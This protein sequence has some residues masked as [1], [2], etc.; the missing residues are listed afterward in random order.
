MGELLDQTAQVVKRTLELGADEVSASMA[1][2]THVTIQRRGGVV[3]QATEAST[4]GLAVS[5]LANDRFT[6]SSTSD[7]RPVA[8]E[9]FLKRCVD[10]ANYLEPDAD[11]ALPAEGLCGRGVTDEALDQYDPAWSQ[12][13]AEQRAE[14]A[15][16][17]E[18]AIHALHNDQVIS[19]AAYVADGAAETVTVMSN[20]FADETRGAWFAA[21]GEMTLQDGAK[22]P[23]AHAYY[24]AR[25]LTDLPDIPFI[26]AELDRRAEQRKGGGPIASGTYPMILENR[27]AARILGVLAGGLSGGALHHGRSFLAGKLGTRIGTDLLHIVDDPLLPRGLGSRPWDGDA[28]RSRK[29]IIVEHGVLREY[30]IDVYHGRKLDMTPTSG[31][32]S[33][34]I[35]PTSAQ[36]WR[37]IAKPWS[38]AILVNGF[39]GGNSNGTTGD[40]SFGILGQ[41][42]ENGEPTSALAEMNVS[43]NANEIFH[44]LAAVGNDPWTYGA[45][46][47]PTLVFEDVTFSGS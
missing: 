44:R 47:T 2:S 27:A 24:G 39:L 29:R 1:A 35:L 46:V 6:S 33:N 9:A 32:R 4:R 16:Q 18:S 26:A 12:Q 10:S 5:I 36:S 40:F 22:R 45:C 7:L 21:G 13:T 31:G 30:N 14:R 11:R 25:H 19:S 23:E 34:W 38:K 42:I 8:L 17:L 28:L 20:G 43:G 37:D 41:L 15:E 3:E